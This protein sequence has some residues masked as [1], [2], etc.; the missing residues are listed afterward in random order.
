MAQAPGLFRGVG[1][2]GLKVSDKHEQVESVEEKKRLTFPDLQ[3]SLERVLGPLI[4]SSGHCEPQF[5]SALDQ[6][7][8]V[9]VDGQ[10]SGLESSNSH[11][12]GAGESWPT[13][14]VVRRLL[15]EATEVLPEL[16]PA[17]ADCRRAQRL[18]DVVFGRLLPAYREFH[19]DLFFHLSDEDLFQPFFVGCCFEAALSL[20]DVD[21]W[22]DEDLQQVLN[23]LN[24]YVGYRPVAT[25]E[26]VQHTTYSHERFRPVPVY[27]RGAGVATGPAQS[28]IKRS[29]EILH[30]VPANLLQEA[31]FDPEHLQELAIDVRAYDFDHPVNKRPNYHFG[32]WDPDR[33][34][35]QGNYT[36]FIVHQMMIE[37]LLKRIEVSEQPREQAEFEVAGTLVG[38]ILMGAGVS[39]SGPDSHD[40][41]VTLSSMMPI[42]ANYRDDYY[43]WLLE[44][45]H[46]PHR[47]SLEK[48]L[49]V[50]RQPFG[51]VRQHLNAELGARRATQVQHVQLSK[52]FAKMGYP[53]AAARQA[54]IVPVTSARMICQ[55]D[56]LLASAAEKCVKRLLHE[57]QADLL[58]IEQ[59]V[60]RGIDCGA[61]LDPWCLLGFDGNYPLFP[62]VENSVADHRADDLVGIVEHTLD[63][64]SHLLAEAA[65]SDDSDLFMDVRANFARMMQW[66]RKY[67]AHEVSSLQAVDAARIM[68]AAELV[69]EALRL[70]KAAGAS[71]GDVRFWAQHA[72]IFDSPKAYQLVVD[73]LLERKDTVASQALLVH[74][75]SQARDIGLVQGETSYHELVLAW[76]GL[77]QDRFNQAENFAQREAVW[78][79]I[80]KFYDYLEVNADEYWQVPEF[81]VPTDSDFG[82]GKS[83]DSS[84]D[85]GGTSDATDADFDDEGDDDFDDEDLEEEEEDDVLDPLFGAAYEDV[86]YTD[87]TDDGVEGPIYETDTSKQDALEA[88]AD[89]IIDRLSFLNTLAI[90]WFE[91]SHIPLPVL[92]VEELSASDIEQVRQRNEVLETWINQAADYQTGLTRLLHHVLSMRLPKSS[93]VSALMEYDRLRLIKE[94]LLDRITAT[95]VE[96]HMAV[97]GLR[98]VQHGLAALIG[99]TPFG[100]LPPNVSEPEWL[101]L[102]AGILTRNTEW[103]SRDFSGLLHELAEKP[104]LYVPLGRGGNADE[105]IST[106]VRQQCFQRALASLPLMGMFQ[107]TVSLLRTARSMERRNS[108]GFGAVTEYDEMFRN[109]FCSMVHALVLAAQDNASENGERARK[110]RKKADAVAEERLFRQLEQL[111]ESMLSAWLNHSR[112][113][114]LSVL[115]KTLDN[116]AWDLTVR[117]IKRYG[118]QIFTQDFLNVGNIRAVLHQG[119]EA[120]LRTLQESSQ[121]LDLELLNDLDHEIT[122]TDAARY[123]SLVL[124]AVLENFSEYRDYNST[125]TQSDRGDLIYTFMDFLRLR[126]KYDRVAWH[127]KPV[128]WAHQVLVKN[129]CNG[130]AGRWRRQLSERVE[131]EAERYLSELKKLQA[132]YSMRMPTVADR[133]S[134]RF[135]QPLHIDRLCAL[136][137]PAI[138]HPDTEAAQGAFELL[139]K[140]AEALTKQPMG[141][142]LEVPAW[143]VQLEQEVD[144]Q[145]LSLPGHNGIVAESLIDPLPLGRD[146]VQQELDHLS[147]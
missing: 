119:V 145:R 132:R 99:D 134:E 46:G 83:L 55:I 30:Q 96:M 65:V 69:A 18:I 61:L 62:A 44:T 97:I 100:E 23:G 102:F 63:I 20:P 111:T 147:D 75:L 146:W 74:W 138:H 57:C 72:S 73:A 86:V 139:E 56:C 110:A 13:L 7:F 40:S 84:A 130:V 25:L 120:W 9:A 11:A 117:F 123:L 26:Q 29:L 47:E 88:E 8:Q 116:D 107:A 136:V 3:V 59:T 85:R 103:V 42:I 10:A 124:E 133:L 1:S 144:L 76:L 17:F 66:W 41:T 113:L 21:E 2:A 68:N 19:V 101:R 78:N 118:G 109:G 98:S 89:R 35:A 64:Y 140:E 38:T 142:G 43:D 6:V 60:V 104:L 122:L 128:V 127:L 53:A 92:S 31:Y 12:G 141:V 81:Q 37:A 80:R 27:I 115:E 137:E 105:M 39:G 14:V 70:W 36:R 114:R 77:Q 5:F 4:F 48:E 54:A 45:V 135:V 82:R 58:Q 33:I 50:K 49:Q 71:A 24:D 121:E 143:L 90:L 28:L 87:S 51:G 131:G 95:N 112:T 79:Q 22:T 34:D 106:R 94:T 129:Q 67:A 16:S 32:L 108:V 125:T 126:T 93:D 52:I 91:A 15:W